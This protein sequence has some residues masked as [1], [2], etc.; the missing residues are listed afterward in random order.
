MRLE[1]EQETFDRLWKESEGDSDDARCLMRV[2]QK[3]YYEVDVTGKTQ[4]DHMP[5]V[6]LAKT[7]SLDG[8]LRWNVNQLV[9]PANGRGACCPSHMWCNLQDGHDRYCSV[10]TTSPCTFPEPR[11]A[12]SSCAYPTYRPSSDGGLGNSYSGCLSDMCRNRGQVLGW[13][14]R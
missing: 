12:S 14:R 7:T 4:L 5:D 2:T 11:G 1:Y 6:S 3:E 10:L 9:P 8:M 13:G